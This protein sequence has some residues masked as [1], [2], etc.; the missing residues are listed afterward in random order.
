[1]QLVVKT[2]KERGGVRDGG[3]RGGEGVVMLPCK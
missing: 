2:L 1:M 3:G